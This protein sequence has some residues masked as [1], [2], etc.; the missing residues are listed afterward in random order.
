MDLPNNS[1]SP[2]IGKNILS[3][4]YNP[5]LKS[6]LRK[7]TSNDFQSNPNPPSVDLIDQHIQNYVKKQNFSSA[8]QIS[9]AL[10]G[11]IDSTLSL[12][13]IRKMH[14]DLKINAISIK[15]AD[16]M[17]ETLMASKIA[18]NLN[19]DHEIISIENFGSH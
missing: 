17:D 5:N 15:F 7:L 10:S 18:N 9:I 19:V 3:L 12:G 13:I 2:S 6:P 11:G 16:S 4:R 14:P 8:K 1:I